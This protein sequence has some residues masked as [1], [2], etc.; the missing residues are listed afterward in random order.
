MSYH[1]EQI[2]FALVSFDIRVSVVEIS[3]GW[4]IWRAM[5]EEPTSV[6]LVVSLQSS[7]NKTFRNVV[8]TMMS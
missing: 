1:F 5:D 8:E 3:M 6:T 7:D 2:G 4:M